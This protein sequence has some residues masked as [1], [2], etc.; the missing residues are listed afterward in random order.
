MKEILRQINSVTGIIGSMA[1]NDQGNLL[2]LAFPPI[3]DEEML[4]TIAT[5]TCENLAGLEEITGG[6]KMTDFRYQNGRVVVK[7]FGYGFLFIVCE[8]TINMQLLTITLN[9]A[10]K[11]I[12]KF[13]KETVVPVTTSIPLAK[14][15][16]Q[17]QAPL[18]HLPVQNIIEMGPLS[19]QLQFI[20]SG[21]AKY[22]GPMAAIIFPECVEKWLQKHQPIKEE[23]SYLVEIAIQEIDTPTK[24]TEFRQRVAHLL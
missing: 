10:M 12:E 18:N 2:A 1:C 13:F 19:S 5:S 16:A 24:A 21:L 15:F 6:V 4:T 7:P 9:V 11:K 23:L 17:P 14:P 20:Q 22:L 8:S 3:F